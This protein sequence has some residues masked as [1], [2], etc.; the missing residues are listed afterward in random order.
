M[1][2]IVVDTNVFL[3]LLLQQKPEHVAYANSV[4]KSVLDDDLNICVP[5]HFDTELGATLIRAQRNKA[6]GIS[7]ADLEEM[8]LNVL[9][10][11]IQTHGFLNNFYDV[12]QAA[13]YYGLTGYDA[14]FFHVAKML[15]CPIATQDRAIITACQRFGV[16]WFNPA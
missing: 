4:I 6:N 13:R 3:S 11:E 12:I 5:L 9:S 16:E 14:P 7:E 8:V 15:N 1:S 10:V 2:N